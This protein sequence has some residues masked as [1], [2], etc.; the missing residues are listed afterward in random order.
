MLS[1]HITTGMFFPFS[2]NLS[3]FQAQKLCLLILDTFHSCQLRYI[4]LILCLLDD[5]YLKFANDIFVHIL[6]EVIRI[7]TRDLNLKIIL[8]PSIM[9]CYGSLFR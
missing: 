7:A 1:S 2:S 8:G 4:D 9:R 5:K 3:T 6:N